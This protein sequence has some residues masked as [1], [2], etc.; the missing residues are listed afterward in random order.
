MVHVIT[1]TE[2]DI[3]ESGNSADDTYVRGEDGMILVVMSHFHA[4][5]N[6]EMVLHCQ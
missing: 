5:D 6:R 4:H 1:S 3:S 2:H